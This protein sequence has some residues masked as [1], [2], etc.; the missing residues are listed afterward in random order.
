M[1]HLDQFKAACNY[2]GALDIEMVEKSLSK[3]LKALGISRKIVQLPKDW[4]LNNLPSLS[5]NINLIL[6]DVK[7]R[8]PSAARAAR[9]ALDASARGPEWAAR[10]LMKKFAEWCVY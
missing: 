1:T 6:D 2:P 8:N 7:K 9:D 10:I 4:E 3:Y 5:R